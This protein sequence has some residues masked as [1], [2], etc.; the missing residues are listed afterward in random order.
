M[1]FSFICLLALLAASWPTA[2]A[3]TL[4]PQAQIDRETIRLSDVFAGLP[5]ETD[6]DIAIAPAPG[7]SV[8]YDYSVLSKLARRYGL[9]WQA[10]NLADKTII[11]RQGQRITTAA[12]RDAVQN[13]LQQ[14]GATGLVEIM[15]D[16]RNLEIYLPLSVKPDFAI[17][18]MHYDQQAQ[19]F[20][21]ELLV[22][23]DTPSFQQISLTGR[24]VPMVEVAT[25]KTAL[26]PGT[27]IS[28]DDVAWMKLPVE[29]A[30]DALR[31]SKAVIGMALRRSLPEQSLLRPADV[32]PPRVV[33][34]GQVVTMRVKQANLELTAQGRA[35][36]DGAVG[37]VV[38]VT[39]TQSNRVI[40]A[41][42]TAP[43]LVEV[44]AAPQLAS[45][46]Q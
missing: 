28:A 34:R 17:H 29:R 6:T 18:D 12:I 7:R 5:P 14:Q 42:V 35:L 36:Q 21:A 39:N 40:E 33:L 25:L 13:Q 1:R 43:G 44:M 10:S 41:K 31:Q 27:T 46:Q 30:G 32:M 20:R 24:V 3:P 11:T 26:P 19:R 22:A 4:Q 23:A 45:L 37:E 15:L 2:A 16:Q 8:T 38:R 9:S